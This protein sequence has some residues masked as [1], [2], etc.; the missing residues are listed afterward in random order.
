MRG[1]L[2]WVLGHKLSICLLKVSFFH[3][4]KSLRIRNFSGRYFPAFGLDTE[5]YGVPLPTQFDC[6]KIRTRKIPST[7]TFHAQCLSIATPSSVTSSLASNDFEFTSNM[8]LQEVLSPRTM[9]SNFTVFDLS[10]LILKHF[11]IL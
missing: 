11:G 3:Y 2:D 4:V 8:Y 10:E 9:N 7:D 1:S 6:G 5:R